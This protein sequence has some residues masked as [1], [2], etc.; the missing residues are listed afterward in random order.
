MFIFYDLVAENPYFYVDGDHKFPGV[1]VHFYIWS[2]SRYE[3]FS[4]D[5]LRCILKPE[6]FFLAHV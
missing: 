1:T 4:I 6:F 5:L 2:R 3:V